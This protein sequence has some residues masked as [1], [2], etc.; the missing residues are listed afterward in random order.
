MAM[1]KK[2]YMKK[3]VERMRKNSSIVTGRMAADIIETYINESD[4]VYMNG[5]Y[6]RDEINNLYK[7]LVVNGESRQDMPASLNIFMTL[8]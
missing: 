5:D 2:E 1:I 8:R 6:S 7:I 3:I 4:A